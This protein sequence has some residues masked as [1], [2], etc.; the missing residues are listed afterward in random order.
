[1]KFVGICLITKNVPALARFYTQ[2]L[3]VQAEG[4]DRHVELQTEGA[5]ISIF[6]VDGM[7]QMAP[8]SMRGAGYGGFTIGFQVD[9]V[10]AEYERLKCLEVELVKLPA[11]YPWGSRSVWFRDPDGNLLD[12]FTLLP[13]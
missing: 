1:M 2:V 10:D 4:D 6:S 7:E 11:S 9:D 8:Q 3:G 5:H 13:K 12:F